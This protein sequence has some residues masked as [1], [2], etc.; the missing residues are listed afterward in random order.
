MYRIG[1]GGSQR[2]GVGDSD[3]ANRKWGS[4]KRTKPNRALVFGVKMLLV[5]PLLLPKFGVD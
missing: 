3:G 1:R 5:V 2:F 4:T